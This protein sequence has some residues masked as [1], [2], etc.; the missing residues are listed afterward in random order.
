M[1]NGCTISWNVIEECFKRDNARLTPKTKLNRTAAYPDSWNKMNVSAA[2]APFKYETITEMMFNLGVKLSCARVMALDKSTSNNIPKT[3]I[4]RLNILKGANAANGKTSTTSTTLATIEYCVHVAI[5]FNEILMNKEVKF[6][7]SN[8]DDYENMVRDSMAYFEDWKAEIDELMANNTENR[9]ELS[10]GFMSIVT[11][12]DLR[13]CVSGFFSYTR[14]ILKNLDND[15]PSELFVPVL[16]SNSSALEAWFS[17]VRSNDMDSS[18]DYATAVSTLYAG[19]GAEALCNSQNKSYSEKDIIVP[20]DKIGA[21]A[22]EQALG[23]NDTWREKTVKEIISTI[24]RDTSTDE[25]Q[26]WSPFS[27]HPENVHDLNTSNLHNGL[28]LCRVISLSQ[29]VGVTHFWDII[30]PSEGK[31]TVHDGEM[32]LRVKSYLTMCMGTSSNSFFSALYGLND[33]G[34]AKLDHACQYLFNTLLLSVR[35]EF[36]KKAKSHM[37][38]SFNYLISLKFRCDN[39]V[40]KMWMMMLPDSMQVSFQLGPSFLVEIICDLFRKLFFHGVKMLSSRWRFASSSN[41]DHSVNMTADVTRILISHEEAICEVQWFF[42]WAVKELIDASKMKVMKNQQDLQTDVSAREADGMLDLAKQ[43]RLLHHEA[44]TDAKYMMQFYPLSVAV[45]NMGGLCLVS[46]PF[47]IIGLLLLKRIRSQLT[48]QRMKAGDRGAISSIYNML[49]SDIELYKCFVECTQKVPNQLYFLSDDCKKKIWRFLVLKTFHARIGV[50]TTRFAEDTTG[51]Y[52]ATAKTDSLRSE[53]K[54]KT[55][56]ASIAKA[57]E[58][59]ANTV[60]S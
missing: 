18:C 21:T 58:Q 19:A 59:S 23:R 12:N 48:I 50:V 52:C 55:R 25:S 49:K 2:K 7:K 22:M 8:I 5:I 20:D 37:V 39:S 17:L 29:I 32:S 44:I 11:Y 33:S 14:T 38:N 34:K 42:G 57:K 35:A 4:N 40:V 56:T 9:H 41:H 51:R 26:S 1:K 13:I 43:M 24:T 3:Y 6:D 45:Y 10:K 46:E 60:K 31:T 27:D 15:N 28:E 30:S 53:L 54:I 16:H 36:T 47:I